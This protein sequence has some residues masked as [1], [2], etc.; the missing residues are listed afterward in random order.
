MK[1]SE[2]I[3]KFQEVQEE[4]GDVEV[5]AAY[6]DVCGDGYYTPFDENNMYYNR[7]ENAVLIQ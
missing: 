6:S 4:Y 3:K 2:L 1:I 7:S 5:M